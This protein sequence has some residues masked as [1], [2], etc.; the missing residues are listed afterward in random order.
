MDF[1]SLEVRKKGDFFLG[2]LRVVSL[3]DEMLD[4]VVD[5]GVVGFGMLW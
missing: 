1:R 4:V 5:V 2:F 3:E